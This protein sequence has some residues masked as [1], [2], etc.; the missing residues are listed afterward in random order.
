MEPRA[1]SSTS[2]DTACVWLS[3]SASGWFW[4]YSWLGILLDLYTV[5]IPGGAGSFLDLWDARVQTKIS[6]MQG[7]CLNFCI[8]SLA[9]QSCF[10][11]LLLFGRVL[12]HIRLCSGL[13][14]QW[15][16]RKTCPILA[17]IWYLLMVSF[18]LWSYKDTLQS[19]VCRIQVVFMVAF[20]DS[21]SHSSFNQFIQPAMESGK[22]ACFW[23]T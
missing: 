11:L 20:C 7:T 13:N 23:G 9:H 8:V 2:Y 21:F 18:R 15:V 17:M 12:Y 16:K 6:L 10:L 4:G 5:I 19:L 3:K 1:A 14:P 22:S